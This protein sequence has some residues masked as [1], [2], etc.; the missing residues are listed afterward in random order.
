MARLVVGPV[1]FTYVHA[2]EPY[3]IDGKGPEKYRVCAV[4]DKNEKTAIRLLERAIEEAKKEG[5]EKKWGGKLPPVGKLTLPLHDGDE[6]RP[7]QEEFK[8]TVY[9]NCSSDIQPEI[10]DKKGAPIIKPTDFYSGCYGNISISIYPYDSGGNR[11]VGIGLNNLQKTED[12]PNL[13]GR[14][15]AADDFKNHIVEDD[16]DFLS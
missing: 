4:I 11:G 14:T 1:R 6:E 2:F 7:D 5:I 8:N 3:A 12:G 16:D 13:T 9:F 15:S 10:L